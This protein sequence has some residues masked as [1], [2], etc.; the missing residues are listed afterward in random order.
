MSELNKYLW[1]RD[2]AY[3]AKRGCKGFMWEATEP[4][5]MTSQSNK[6]ITR[7]LEQR[8]LIT[9]SGII[10]P[11]PQSNRINFSCRIVCEEPDLKTWVSEDLDMLQKPLRDKDKTYQHSITQSKHRPRDG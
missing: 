11:H 3:P 4:K 10:S 2:R 1:L 7:K 9:S 5:L 8:R 6:K